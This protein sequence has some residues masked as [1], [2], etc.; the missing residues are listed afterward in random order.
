MAHNRAM[1]RGI[2]LGTETGELVDRGF[3]LWGLSRMDAVKEIASIL[4]QR[5][6]MLIKDGIITNMGCK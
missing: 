4:I 6:P 3:H 2:Q 5:F 1:A